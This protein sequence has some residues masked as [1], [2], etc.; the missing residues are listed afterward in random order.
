[1]PLTEQFHFVVARIPQGA[2]NIPLRFWSMLR[3]SHHQFLQIFQLHFHDESL[4]FYRVPKVFDWI[5]I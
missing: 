2:E 4:S 1:M 5:R 3:R